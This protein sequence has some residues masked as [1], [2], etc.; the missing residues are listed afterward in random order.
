MKYLYQNSH[1]KGL[2]TLENKQCLDT[3][4]SGRTNQP[5]YE[6]SQVNDLFFILI[7]FIYV[8]ILRFPL[9]NL[10]LFI[11][12]DVQS[13]DVLQFLKQLGLKGVCVCVYEYV[14]CMKILHFALTYIQ[15][16]SLFVFFCVHDIAARLWIFIYNEWA[17][18]S[19]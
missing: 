12:I 6:L 16:P 14:K 1:S 17:L 10:I 11:D 15:G 3:W 9:Y 7:F 18:T 5:R 8:F 2:K 4:L 13:V 19:L